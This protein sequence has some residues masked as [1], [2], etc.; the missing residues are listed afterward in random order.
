MRALQELEKN[1]LEIYAIGR[2]EMDRKEYQ[3]F[4]CSDWCDLK[5]RNSIHYLNVDFKNLNFEDK[6]S[7]KGINYFYISLP[8]LEYKNV[9]KFLEKFID[10]GYEIKVLVEKPFGKDLENAKDLKN[11]IEHSNLKGDL[12]ISDHYLFKESFMNLPKKFNQIKIVSI[13]EIG[14]ENRVTYYDKTGA[15]KDM[16]QSHFLNLILK[17]LKFKINLNEIEILNFVKGQY[18]DYSKELGKKS[19]TETFANLKF[20]CCDKEFEFI[21]GKG[22][23]KKESFVEIDGK[24]FVDEF[25][26]SYVEIFKKF[27]DL[28]MEDFPTI[29]DSILG[30]EIIEKFEKFGR[31]KELKIYEK[32]GG[33][34]EVLGEE[35]N[36]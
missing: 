11:F 24:K 30:W 20:K 17:N 4:I 22:F 15:L 8:P 25:D 28:K 35:K 23:A 16:I 12:F 10:K 13:E 27:F 5:F 31:G 19:L 2:R 18:K 26:N 36:S 33:L 7:E 3:N 14:L 29:E 32:D 1:D 34:G 9:F 21:T 6:L